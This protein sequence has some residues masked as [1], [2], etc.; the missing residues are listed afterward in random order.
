ME[1]QVKTIDPKED[2]QVVSGSRRFQ[3][4]LVDDDLLVS[5][6][7]NSSTSTSSSSFSTSNDSKDDE[8]QGFYATTKPTE[9]NHLLG[10]LIRYLKPLDYS[11]SM[12]SILFHSPTKTHN[13][14]LYCTRQLNMESQRLQIQA[15]GSFGLLISSAGRAV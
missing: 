3:E 6:S 4:K 5:S 12:M 13:Q 1:E 10:L 15:V 11:K 8:D 2:Q 9:K 14:F 7:N